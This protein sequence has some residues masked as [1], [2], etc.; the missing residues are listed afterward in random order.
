MSAEQE[1]DLKKLRE[2]QAAND[3]LI[4]NEELHKQL[5]MVKKETR[6]EEGIRLAKLT[7]E[8]IE[9]EKDQ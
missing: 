4:K 2:A 8:A 5:S 6:E 3:S 9:K 7:K 1:R